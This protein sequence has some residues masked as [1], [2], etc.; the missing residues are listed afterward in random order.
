MDPT[1]PKKDPPPK[2]EDPVMA[3]KP[4]SFKTDVLPIL[5]TNCLNCHGATGKP[6]GDVDLTTL[7]KLMKSGKKMLV[8]GKPDESDFYTSITERGMPKDRPPIS[9]GDKLVLKNW[10]LTGGKE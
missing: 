7:A 5:R 8:A 4:V 1:P 10:I 2:K 6:K 9:E 3:L